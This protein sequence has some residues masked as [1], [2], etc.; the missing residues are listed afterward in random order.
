M[1]SV[2][3]PFRHC[4]SLQ[5]LKGEDT[6]LELF[7]AAQNVFALLARHSV[8]LHLNLHKRLNIEITGQCTYCSLCE[9]IVQGFK[10]VSDIVAVTANLLTE[11]FHVEVGGDLEVVAGGGYA[12]HFAH[13][14]LGRAPLLPVLR[15]AREAPQLQRCEQGCRSHWLE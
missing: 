4:A 1:L 3:A 2:T 14:E 5:V 11:G 9:D 8:L 13:A 15:L 12:A 10:F 7:S 6:K